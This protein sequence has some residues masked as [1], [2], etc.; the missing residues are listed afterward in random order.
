VARVE[1]RDAR[2]RKL[3]LAAAAAVSSRLAAALGRAAW[4]GSLMDALLRFGAEYGRA[5]LRAEGGRLVV[6]AGQAE[7]VFEEGEGGEVRV[8]AALKVDLGDPEQLLLLVARLAGELER[9]DGKVGSE[10]E[11]LRQLE[12]RLN[13]LEGR[14]ERLE[15]AARLEGRLGEGGEEGE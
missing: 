3:P 10:S 11:R 13:R 4:A 6:D 8:T 5:P 1:V 14:L 7:V 15:W 2:G 12:G 9:L